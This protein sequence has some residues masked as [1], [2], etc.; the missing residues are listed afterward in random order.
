MHTYKYI[1]SESFHIPTNIPLFD[2]LFRITTKKISD[3][4]ITGLLVVEIHRWQNST[5]KKPIMAWW[6]HQ[7]ETFSALLPI[8]AGNSPV[9]GE[10]PAQWPVT[11]SFDV[12]FDLR[13][14]KRLSKQ[15]RGRRFETPSWPYCRHFI[16]ESVSMS[17]YYY[18]ESSIFQYIYPAAHREISTISLTQGM[19]IEKINLKCI[20]WQMQLVWSTV[21][22]HTG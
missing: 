3:S 1:R 5:H 20:P 8:C 11:R 6:R 15:S 19:A 16:E 2:S 13:L 17:W 4:S 7:K 22:L 18:S 21:D 10:F 9:T 14:K 12:Y